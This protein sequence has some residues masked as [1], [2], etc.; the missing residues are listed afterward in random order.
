MSPK[1][2]QKAVRINPGAPKVTFQKHEYYLSKTMLF[3]VQA[4]PGEGKKAA[5]TT[6]QTPSKNLF[7]F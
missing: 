5:K 2:L 3:E 1:V 6:L 4:P 7:D